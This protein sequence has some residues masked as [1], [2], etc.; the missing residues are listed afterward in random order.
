MANCPFLGTDEEGHYHLISDLQLPTVPTFKTNMILLIIM[1][2]LNNMSVDLQ[3]LLGADYYSIKDGCIYSAILI[4]IK[5][6]R[7]YLIIIKHLDSGEN[8]KGGYM[9]KSAKMVKRENAGSGVFSL[10]LFVEMFS[11]MA[12]IKV[13]AWFLLVHG[14]SL[15]IISWQNHCE[16]YF[17]V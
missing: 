10:L 12:T 13:V 15:V 1:E 6:F 9:G 14:L 11:G 4:I 3:H 16:Y 7:L 17:T 8:Y 2:S 5:T